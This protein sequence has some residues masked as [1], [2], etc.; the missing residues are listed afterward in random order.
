MALKRPD[1]MADMVIDKCVRNKY[2]LAECLVPFLGL[3]WCTLS[4]YE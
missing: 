4:F 2:M 1:T 3:I